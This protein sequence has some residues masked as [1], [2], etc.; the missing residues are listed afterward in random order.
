MNYYFSTCK[1]KVLIYILLLLLFYSKNNNEKA[2]EK[3]LLFQYKVH[4]ELVWT[5]L[6]EG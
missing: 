5:L 4:G 3:E 1:F 2:S 6:L